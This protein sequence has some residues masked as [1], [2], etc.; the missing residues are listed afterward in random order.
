MG[1][2]WDLCPP[3]DNME[4]LYVCSV[5]TTNTPLL[6]HLGLHTNET[7]KW[8][9]IDKRAFSVSLWIQETSLTVIVKL[10]THLTAPL[11]ALMMPLD[12][13]HMGHHVRNT[14]NCPPKLLP[15]A[16]TQRGS[17]PF[18]DWQLSRVKY[19]FFICIFRPLGRDLLY[20]DEDC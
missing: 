11:P 9:W 14:V 8:D 20:L 6:N 4:A 16:R 17:S 5:A 18:L 10:S 2:T 1:F 12:M 7:H 19:P 13:W 3:L 15:W